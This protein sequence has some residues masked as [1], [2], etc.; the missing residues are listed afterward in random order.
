MITKDAVELL[1]RIQK[2]LREHPDRFD[3]DRWFYDPARG[4]ADEPALD[5]W[6]Q[7][8][9][10]GPHLVPDVPMMKG[11]TET[12]GTTACIAGWAVALS[13]ERVQPGMSI[14]TEAER[15]L[16]WVR[17]ERTNGTTGFGHCPLFHVGRWPGDLLDRHCEAADRT[18]EQA[19]IACEAVDR[20]IES[21]G[22]PNLFRS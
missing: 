21:G 22:D 9:V 16:G 12:C 20:W 7:Y 5:S 1:R 8:V 15:L 19:E 13:G 17:P 10:E 18:A 14:Q 11:L 6:G 2:A 4:Y 3:M